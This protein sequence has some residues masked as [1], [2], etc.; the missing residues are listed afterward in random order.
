MHYHNFFLF[1]FRP[2]ATFYNPPPLGSNKL[3][4]A[5]V[6]LTQ[7][8]P[9]ASLAGAALLGLASMLKDI[10][11]A[12][13]AVGTSCR[14]R[15]PEHRGTGAAQRRAALSIVLPGAEGKQLLVLKGLLLR[16]FRAT[17]TFAICLSVFLSAKQPFLRP[18]IPSCCC[19]RLQR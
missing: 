17:G 13:A 5:W 14:Q 15:E 18:S 12:L 7:F 9:T 2:F 1:C 4:D 3:S 19:C 6:L 11:E 8:H 10:P 16:A